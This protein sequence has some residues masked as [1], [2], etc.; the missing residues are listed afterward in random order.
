MHIDMRMTLN[1]SVATTASL[2][3]CMDKEVDNR[4]G[5]RKNREKAKCWLKML[6]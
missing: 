6:Q 3:V 5:A 1:F 4:K 2:F